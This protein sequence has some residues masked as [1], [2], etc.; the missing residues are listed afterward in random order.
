MHIEEIP[1]YCLA[2]PTVTEGFHFDQEV[3]VFK[4]I[5]QLFYTVNEMYS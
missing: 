4:V 3:L 2:K 5:Q 1:D